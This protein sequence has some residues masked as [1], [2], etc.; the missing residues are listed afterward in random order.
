MTSW[1]RG[2]G[3][4]CKFEE[5]RVKP[6]YMERELTRERKQDS[7]LGSIENPL[8]IVNIEE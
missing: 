1:E 2:M 7:S 5:M 4:R 3:R 8:V 6:S